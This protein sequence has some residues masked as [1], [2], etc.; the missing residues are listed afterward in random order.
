M[1]VAWLAFYDGLLAVALLAAGVV[2]A[3]WAFMT[4]LIGFST[5]LLGTLVGLIALLLGLVG[6]FVT[7]NPAR[8]AARPRATIGMVLGVVTILPVVLI[9]LTSP[10]VPAIN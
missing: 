8:A 6:I 9:I 4:P 7:R 10:K 3:H 1:I 2:G 5:F